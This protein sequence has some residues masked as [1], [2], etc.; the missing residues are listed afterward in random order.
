MSRPDRRWLELS[1]RCPSA[2]ERAGL[3]AEGLVALG[4]RAVEERAG[5]FVTHLPHAGDPADVEDRV[6]SVLESATGLTG[7][8]LRLDWR[9]EEEWAE[10]WKRGLGVR[11]ITER[12]VVRPTW[13]EYAPASAHE[14]VIELDPGM[15]F[16]TAEHGTT[17][18]CLR[19]LD[20][21]VLRGDEVVDVGSGS[22]VLAVAA[23]RLGASSV[24]AIEGDPLACEALRQNLAANAVAGRVRVVEAWAD[25]RLLAAHE[26]A[27][28]VV[29]NIETGI[30]EPLFPALVR[31]VAPGGWLVL[32]GITTDEWPA[33]RGAIERLGAA[34]LAEDADE[35]WISGAFRRPDRPRKRT[36]SA[37]RGR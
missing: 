30:L 29:A 27:S 2:G 33:V 19:L 35:G 15:A 32:S 4:G 7:L 18:G 20:R 34:L 13:V 3:L 6:A 36:P 8:E 31:A 21:L 1:V 11:R 22:G 5:W 14:I 9:R 16:G 24:A 25:P 17:R 37:R 23:A 28:G 12:I 10:T 26:G